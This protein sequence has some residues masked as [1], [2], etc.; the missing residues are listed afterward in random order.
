MSHLRLVIAAAVLAVV[1][2]CGHTTNSFTM[3]NMMDMMD[4]VASPDQ[5]KATPIPGDSHAAYIPKLEAFAETQGVLVL[6]YPGAESDW[7]TFN[8]I[9]GIIWINSTMSP[10]QQ[11]AT[12]VHEIGHVLQPAE[13]GIGGPADVFAEAVSFIYCNRIGL[14]TAHSSFA[15]LR[16]NGLLARMTIHQY[17]KE[18]NAVVDELIRVIQ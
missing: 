12:L 8:H 4:R 3:L 1:M 15:Y 11:V 5:I 10:N 7:G 6:S 2:A 13:L 14:D 17:E 18:I 16:S 9:T